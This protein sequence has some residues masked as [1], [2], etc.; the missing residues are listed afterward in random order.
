M[1]ARIVSIVAASSNSGK[2]TLIEK[3]IAVFKGRGFRVAVIKHASQGFDLDSA[4]KDS[5]RFQQA[6][7]DAVLLA[8]QGRVALLKKSDHEPA[9]HELEQ[10]AGDADIVIYEGFKKNAKNK[11]EVY[12]DGVS[13]DQPLSLSDDSFLALVSDRHVGVQVPWFD[14]NDA[15]GVAAFILSRPAQ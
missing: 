4:G 12:R 7:A 6:G 11:I 13:G 9:F 14:I 5:W 2:T 10:L 3:L 8:G 15:E 1:A